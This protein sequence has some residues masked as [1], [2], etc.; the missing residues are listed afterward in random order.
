MKKKSGRKKKRTRIL[1][2]I[3]VGVVFFAAGV[4][5]VPLLQEKGYQIKEWITKPSPPQ[6]M[7]IVK[8]YFSESAGERLVSE[9]RKIIASPQIDQEA[10]L[11]LKEL[12]E[13]PKDSS[14]NPTLPSQTEIRAV[15]VKDDCF[16]VDFS[17]SLKEKHPGGSTGELLT[18]YSI[19]N[20]L[21]ENFPSQSQVQI[22]IQGEPAE[23]LAGHI[24]IRNPLS[25]NFSVVKQ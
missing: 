20:T 22:L 7:K 17:S 5:V 2:Y 16:Y 23:T 21:L 6:E 9:E 4:L 11:I 18:I 3:L 25:K 12:I 14:L 19:V 13:G 15:Y 1:I 8:L 10:K 24:D